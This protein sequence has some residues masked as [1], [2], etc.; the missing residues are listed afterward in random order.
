[1]GAFSA[2]D[3]ARLMSPHENGI[4]AFETPAERYHNVLTSRF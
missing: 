3:A 1:M 2:L 4:F